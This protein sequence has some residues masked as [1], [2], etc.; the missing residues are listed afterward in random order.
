[1]VGK[2]AGTLRQAL[3]F[4]RSARALAGSLGLLFSHKRM[5]PHSFQVWPVCLHLLH[6][7]VSVV[8]VRAAQRPLWA[9]TVGLA[10]EQSLPSSLRLVFLLL[11]PEQ[12][13][14]QKS[15]GKRMRWG[16]GGARHWPSFASSSL[17][18]VTPVS[19]FKLRTCHCS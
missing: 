6:G 3:T 7:Q 10:S 8:V 11:K 2:A 16:R 9:L 19:A 14:S 5:R 18:A 13:D 12:V 17:P 15:V 4:S 1:M